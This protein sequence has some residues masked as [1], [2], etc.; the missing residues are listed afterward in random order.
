MN[1]FCGIVSIAFLN[2]LYIE[3]GIYRK[4]R[5]ESVAV[6]DVHIICPIGT[7]WLLE[8]RSSLLTLFCFRVPSMKQLLFNQHLEKQETSLF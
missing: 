8:I 5:T 2:I 1:D 3:D 6:E 7:W 4:K